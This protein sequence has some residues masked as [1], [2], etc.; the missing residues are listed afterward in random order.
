MTSGSFAFR[1]I[2]C[3]ESPCDAKARTEWRTAA[4]T[5]AARK[6][7]PETSPTTSS[8]L[9][10]RSTTSYQSPPTSVPATPGE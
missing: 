1:R 6:P 3:G 4:M 9:E 10:P 8:V 5:L 2:I 7:R